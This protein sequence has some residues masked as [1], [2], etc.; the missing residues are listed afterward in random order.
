[1]KLAGAI[2]E[3]SGSVNEDGFGL[4]EN[5]GAV[6]AAWIFDG[7]TGIN[8]ANVL[9]GGSDAA[10]L[11]A[12]AGHHLRSLATEDL[13]LAMILSRLVDHL[14][15]DWQAVSAHLSL[16]PGYDPP[17]ACLILAKKYPD[18][19]K[20]LRLG[21]S[22]LIARQADGGHNLLTASPNNAFDHWLAG[23]ARKRRDAGMLD[24]G[25]LL[26]EFHH[27]LAAGRMK[28]NRPGGYSILEADK[29]ALAMP[30]LIGLGF[31]RA[32]LLCTD[33]FYRA[34]D[35]YGIHDDATLL[36][37][38]AGDGGVRRVLAE[39]RVVEAGDPACEKYLRFKPAD[40]A[41]AVAL[42]SE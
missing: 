3:G 22:C 29:A 36:T 21:D 10:W 37:A 12:Q 16:P 14:M 38:C 1:M 31:P 42:V 11:V 6:S 41:T 39:V 19:W 15:A 34:V 32:L 8:G 33:G 5:A 4:I 20:A 40:D 24:I 2:S 9:P 26:A 25:A 13:P 7:V 30:E 35:H 28:R 17:A 18:G 23:E 27:E